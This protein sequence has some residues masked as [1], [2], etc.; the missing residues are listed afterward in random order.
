M[1]AQLEKKFLHFNTVMPK[2]VLEG[3]CSFVNIPNE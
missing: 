1:V 2:A 3:H